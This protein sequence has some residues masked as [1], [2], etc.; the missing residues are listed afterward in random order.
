LPEV[1][2]FPEADDMQRLDVGNERIDFRSKH[3]RVVS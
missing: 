2:D 1:S 3:L